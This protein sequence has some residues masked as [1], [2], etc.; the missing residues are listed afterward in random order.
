MEEETDGGKIDINS[1]SAETLTLLPGIGEV[2]A[3][4]IISYREAHG[5]FKSVDELLEI[6]GIGPA[7]LEGL[8]EYITAEEMK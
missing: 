7:I 1:A 2:R 3:E 4:A 5:G 6:D 8:E